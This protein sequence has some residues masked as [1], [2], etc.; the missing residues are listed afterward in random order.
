M[1]W[2]WASLTAVSRGWSR[3]MLTLWSSCS[4]FPTLVK[5]KQ[6]EEDLVPEFRTTVFKQPDFSEAVSS[7][8]EECTSGSI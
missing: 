1:T 8:D 3:V 5:V 2:E 6:R 7:M 4:A